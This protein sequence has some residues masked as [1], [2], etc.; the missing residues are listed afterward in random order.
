MLIHI[1]QVYT[2]AH[3]LPYHFRW[4]AGPISLLK[5]K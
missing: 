5:A 4:A 3:S 2:H 1:V